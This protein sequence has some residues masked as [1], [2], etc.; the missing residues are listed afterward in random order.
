MQSKCLCC[1]WIFWSHL[2]TLIISFLVK[3]VLVSFCFG[4]FSTFIKANSCVSS[5]SR[6]AVLLEGLSEVFECLWWM[7]WDK[8]CFGSLMAWVVCKADRFVQFGNVMSSIRGHIYVLIQGTVF[9]SHWKV[10]TAMLWLKRSIVNVCFFRNWEQAMPRFSTF[11]FFFSLL[12]EQ[13]W[14]TILQRTMAQ[15]T[16]LNS[17]GYLLISWKRY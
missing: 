14:I 3:N 6:A 8:K 9:P 7:S 16:R 5:V 10:L 15:R 13:N 11:L 4:F 17:K 12:L 2:L 1:Q